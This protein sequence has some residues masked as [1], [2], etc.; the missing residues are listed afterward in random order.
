MT[1]DFDSKS[2]RTRQPMPLWAGA[3]DRATSEHT[4][5]VIGAYMLILMAMWGSK[6]CDLPAD[7]KFLSRVA[8]VSPT[9][10]RR[11]LAPII[12]PMLS[13]ENLR[14][15]S[16]KLQENA[17]KTEEYCRKQHEKKAGKSGAKVLKSKEQDQSADA[18]ED[19]STDQPPE[20]PKPLTI[21]LSKKEEEDAHARE[22]VSISE[23]QENPSPPPDVPLGLIADLR[24]AVGVKS[25]EAGAYWSDAAVTAHVAAWRSAGLTDDQI[26]AE[27]KASRAKNPDPPH[28]PKALDAWMETAARARRNAPVPG[29]PVQKAETKPPATPEERLKFY[30]DWINGAKPFPPSAISTT[31]AHSL[32]AAGLVTRDQFR[33]RGVSV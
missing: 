9:I 10:W 19:V 6:T 2:A 29:K 12:L 30:A 11:R 22:A 15:F 17:E 5:E 14:I 7:E 13:E 4:A 16:K 28:G 24:H 23:N 18:S 21:N 8:R 20:N 1:S 33:S 25:H 3:F 26:I 32:L 27:A 31:L